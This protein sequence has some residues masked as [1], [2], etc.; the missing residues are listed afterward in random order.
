M[1]KIEFYN[2]LSYIVTMQCRMTIKNVYKAHFAVG[3]INTK[4]RMPKQFTE[5]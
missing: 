5:I 3:K 4:W 2:L 1:F